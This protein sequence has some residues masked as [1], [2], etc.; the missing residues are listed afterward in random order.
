[1]R[2]LKG[3]TMM[4][5]GVGLTLSMG[6][7]CCKQRSACPWRPER[8]VPQTVGS[9]ENARLNPMAYPWVSMPPCVP[10]VASR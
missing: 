9:A 7:A 4:L 8:A 10:Q 3:I 6:C 2:T 5:L 1:M